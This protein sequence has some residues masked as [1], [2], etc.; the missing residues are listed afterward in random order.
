M[1]SYRRYYIDFYDFRSGLENRPDLHNSRQFDTAEAAKACVQSL[2]TEMRQIK[3]I[4]YFL[5]RDIWLEHQIL[6]RYPV[7]QSPLELRELI[8]SEN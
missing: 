5:A 8:Y 4:G 1:H 6:D 2:N 3:N 7:P